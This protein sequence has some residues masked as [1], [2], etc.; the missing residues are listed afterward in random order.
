MPRDKNSKEE[1]AFLEDLNKQNKDFKDKVIKKYELSSD[2]I[3][4]GET[5]LKI[6]L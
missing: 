3:R 6:L 5:F 2:D 1:K 4:K